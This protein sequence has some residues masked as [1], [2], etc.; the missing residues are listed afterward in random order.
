MRHGLLRRS[1]SGRTSYIL[2]GASF[3]EEGAINL[4]VQGPHGFRRKLKRERFP[5]LFDDIKEL[6]DAPV[7]PASRGGAPDEE[8]A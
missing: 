6:M 5:G 2:V 3:D 1:E 8:A 7:Q 4:F